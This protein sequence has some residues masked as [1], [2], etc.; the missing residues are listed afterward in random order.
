MKNTVHTFTVIKG[1]HIYYIL[2]LFIGGILCSICVVVVTIGVSQRLNFGL[3][4]SGL[5]LGL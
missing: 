5:H 3:M 1:R 4:A 2:L